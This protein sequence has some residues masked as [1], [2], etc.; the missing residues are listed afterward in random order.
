MDKMSESK[1]RPITGSSTI[2]INVNGRA[3]KVPVN[4]PLSNQQ[5][6]SSA[7]CSCTVQSLPEMHP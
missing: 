4:N 7:G 2:T 5:R 6:S 3:V 1:R